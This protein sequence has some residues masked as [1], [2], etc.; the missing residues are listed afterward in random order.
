[1]R[2]GRE[3][4]ALAVPAAV[5]A[6]ADPV[7]AQVHVFLAREEGAR[8]VLPG[9]SRVAELRR[10][11]SATET[12][13]LEARLGCPLDEGGFHAFVGLE[14]DGGPAG[15]ALIVNEVGKVQPITF[16][17][18]VDPAGRVAGVEVLAYREEIGGEVRHER[19]LRQYLGKDLGSPVRVGRDIVHITGATL[20]CHAACRAVRK[21]LAVHEL[22]FASGGAAVALEAAA[23]AAWTVEVGVRDPEAPVVRT[24]VLMGTMCS[25]CL[26]EP[27]GEKDREATDRAADAAF[28]EI[29]RWEAILSPF[30][31]DSEL[32]RL[33][34]ALPA[35]PVRPTPA[36]G[37]WLLEALG[38]ARSTG[39]ASDPT[40]G[41]LVECW[42]RA[43]AAGRTPTEAERREALARVG[44]A[45]VHLADGLLEAHDGMLLDPCAT[46]K[47]WAVD[48]A[49]EVLRAR[50]V[51]SALVNL[52]GDLYALGAPPGRPGWR[53]AVR[54]PR[55]PEWL[56]GV[57][58]VRDRAV[59]SSGAYERV[60]V[61]GAGRHAQVLDPF[62][63][64][65]VEAVAGSVAVAASAVAADA[66]ATASMV[67]GGDAARAV[68]AAAGAEGLLVDALDPA[69]DAATP[70]WEAVFDPAAR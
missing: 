53:V 33:N 14:A 48:R 30:R 27:E 54:D 65:P 16:V 59:A 63:G 55:R 47:G 45:R 23:H 52:G 17:V 28:A 20:S 26:F 31:E 1:M 8:R 38:W 29:A 6:W 5:V 25:V 58:T 36:L 10:H 69:R 41:A 70:G 57:L 39:G 43:V 11:L 40:A 68:L 64:V 24:L 13:A 46:G 67:L 44:H 2:A 32:S 34:A 50:G 22:L 21:A 12:S 35:G 66:L 42:R 49:V 18:G 19:F 62:T 60:W 15:V 56:Q 9:A 4:W 3:V 61:V 37:A 7:L 51:R